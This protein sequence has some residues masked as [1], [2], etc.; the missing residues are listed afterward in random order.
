MVPVISGSAIAAYLIISLVAEQQPPH[1]WQQG[2]LQSVLNVDPGF[3]T[4]SLLQHIA[5]VVM[6]PR[7]KL[8][9]CTDALGVFAEYIA[10]RLPA[11]MG[12]QTLGEAVKG[13]ID[14]NLHKKITLANLSISLHCSTVTLTEHF[15]KEFGITIMQYVL[16]RRMELAQKLLADTQLP[17]KEISRR[18]GFADVE[19]FSRCFRDYSGNSPTGWREQKR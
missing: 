18:C 10:S 4:D 15:R 3:D 13:Y 9:D 6:Y 14:K 12:S 17:V 19:Y 8:Q 5:A 11:D 7:Q 1:Y 16:S 2:A